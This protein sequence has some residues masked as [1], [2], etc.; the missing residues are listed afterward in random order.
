M[1]LYR[2][3]LLILLTAQLIILGADWPQWR[4]PGRD[5]ISSETRISLQMVTGEFSFGEKWY[6]T[7]IPAD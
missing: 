2:L 4:G 1:F 5:G 7:L 6:V 3:T